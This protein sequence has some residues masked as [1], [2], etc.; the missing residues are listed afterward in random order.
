MS[1]LILDLKAAVRAVLRARFVSGL[2]VLAFALGIGVT[3]VVF[4]I[5]NS[6]LLRPL[7]YPHPER[8]VVVYDTQ[9][10][11]ATCPA[12]YPKY[13]EWKTRSRVFVAIGGSSGRSFAMT[14]SG[15]PKRVPA[16]ATTASLGE[17]FGVRPQIGRWYSEDE[18]R[19]GGPKVV[20]LTHAFWTEHF[21][22]DP[23]IVGRT[24]TFDGD[25][26]EVIGVM[27]EGFIHRRASV[28]VPLQRKLDPAT[29]GNHFL[30]TYARLKSDV[31]L[32]RGQTEMR[33]LGQVL[34]REF[35]YNHGIDVQSYTE[36]VIGSV[37]QP[38]DVLMGAVFL[39]LLIACA[40]V[41]N[42][43]L[44]SG[45]ARRRELAIRLALGAGQS[46]LAR[47]LTAESL[48]LAAAGGAIGVL[49]ASWAVRTFVTLAGTILP[50]A[51]TVRI[52]GR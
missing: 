42:L 44:A 12:S 9:P 15:E 22:R 3:P 32:E 16:M 28:F 24:L 46:D 26:Y 2:A 1:R 21:G 34:A 45:L 31:T 7:P 36:V 6:V 37:R 10:A 39:V 30:A 38:L 49:L 48:V 50:R 8:L 19:P 20:V 11:C 52:D 25:S 14:G 35:S 40:N 13:I 27:P 18:D 47:Q 33:A 41:A 5:F 43:L 23:G 29:R 4:I 51:N 17:V